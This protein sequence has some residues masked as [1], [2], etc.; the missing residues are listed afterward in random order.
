MQTIRILFC[1]LIFAFAARALA[2]PPVIFLVRHAER[3][4]AGRTQEKN[5]DLSA[6]GKSRAEALSRTLRD[7][8]ITAIFTTEY[9]RTQETAAPLADSL[10]VKPQIVAAKG[11]AAL[12][13][14]LKESSGNALVVGH[15]NTLPEIAQ[16]LGVSTTLKIGETDYDDLFVVLTGEAPRLIHLHYR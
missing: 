4:D 14:K 13:G 7:A 3:A 6:Q 12:I 11:A 8:G 2:E 10:G 9:K 5:P 1:L 15:S 16:S